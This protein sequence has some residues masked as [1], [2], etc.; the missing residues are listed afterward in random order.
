MLILA[1]GHLLALSAPD[2]L[3][4]DTCAGQR[5]GQRKPGDGA[6]IAGTEL[7][8]IKMSL[9]VTVITDTQTS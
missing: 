1:G 6:E 9:L 2:N 7:P 5:E 3:C 8:G 4:I